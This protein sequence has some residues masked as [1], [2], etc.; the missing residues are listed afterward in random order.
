M[1]E[2]ATLGSIAGVNLDQVLNTGLGVY[3]TVKGN[4]KTTPAAPVIVTPTAAPVATASS[5][6]PTWV[7]WTIGGIVGI[8]LIVGIVLI[9]RR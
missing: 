1:A 4:K 8:G 3:T 5:K 6:I 9:A 7:K 2:T